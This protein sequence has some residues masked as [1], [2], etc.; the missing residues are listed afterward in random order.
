MMNWKGR[1]WKPLRSALRQVY[2]YNPRIFV[3]ILI[4]VLWIVSF[5]IKNGILTMFPDSKLKWEPPHY[6]IRSEHV[7][8]DPVTVTLVGDEDESSFESVLT[9]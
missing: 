2:S 3:E 8:G 7:S 9:S 1:G 4:T 5:H 6:K